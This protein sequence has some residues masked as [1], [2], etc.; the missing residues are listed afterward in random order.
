MT[1]PIL[2]P[3]IHGYIQAYYI[4]VVVVFSLSTPSLASKLQGPRP[5]HTETLRFMVSHVALLATVALFAAVM[6]EI[7]KL[8][9]GG[10]PALAGLTCV[11]IALGFAALLANRAIVRAMTPSRQLWTRPKIRTTTLPLRA[12]TAILEEVLYRGYLVVLCQDIP[13]ILL[14]KAALV[15]TILAFALAHIYAGLPNALAKLPLGIMALASVL[16]FDALLPAI[17]AHLVFNIFSIDQPH[18][19]SQQVGT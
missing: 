3:E 16:T 18:R 9:P 7:P 5:W 11:G 15:S 12:L 19:E 14:S 6:L 8:L 17:A 2:T 1:F 13:N 10:L 4:A